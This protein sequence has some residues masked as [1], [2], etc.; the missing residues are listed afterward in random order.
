[1]GEVTPKAAVPFPAFPESQLKPIRE[2]EGSLATQ[3]KGASPRNTL[4]K[5][6]AQLMSVNQFP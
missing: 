6:P 2:S 1:M 4:G 3:P 5:V